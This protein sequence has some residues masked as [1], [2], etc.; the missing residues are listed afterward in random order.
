LKKEDIARYRKATRYDVRKDIPFRCLIGKTDAELHIMI[1]PDPRGDE[2]GTYSHFHTVMMC[3]NM[4]IVDVP[5]PDRCKITDSTCPFIAPVGSDERSPE[6]RKFRYA[7]EIIQKI[8]FIEFYGS[9]LVNE[10]LRKKKLTPIQYN[11]KVAELE[12]ILVVSDLIN[13][14]TYQK[15]GNLRRMRNKLAH[16]PKEYLNFREKD[17][18]ECSREADRL[19]YVVADLLKN[20]SEKKT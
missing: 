2:S 3:P 12:K 14:E 4:K 19:S 20:T 18:Y 6:L 13:A 8:A 5:E 7:N 1:E 17:L 11:L 10:I 15:V 16:S 9:Q